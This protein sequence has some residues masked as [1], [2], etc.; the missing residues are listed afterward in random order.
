MYHLLCAILFL[1][2]RTEEYKHLPILNVFL[3]LGTIPLSAVVI[4]V[5]IVLRVRIDF[6]IKPMEDLERM[7][8]EE[9]RREQMIGEDKDLANSIKKEM[10]KEKERQ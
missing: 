4:C 7:E 6:M 2:V 1:A 3:Y 10:A 8:I 9:M 5:T